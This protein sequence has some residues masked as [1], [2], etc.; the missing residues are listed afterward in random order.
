MELEPKLR[1]HKVVPLWTLPDKYGDPFNL[2]KKRGR[3][4]YVV[5]VCAPGVDPAPY[6][7]ELAPHLAELRV[8]QIAAIVVVASED[9]AG[10]LPGLPYRVVIDADGK[11]RDRYLP[12]GA[13]AGIFLLDRYADLYRQWLVKNLSE[14][15]PAEEIAGWMQAISMQCSV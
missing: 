1:E 3:D 7:E 14:L 5:L 6:L 11:V 2:A 12:A 13:N 10:A 15:P 9:A 4:H 8:L